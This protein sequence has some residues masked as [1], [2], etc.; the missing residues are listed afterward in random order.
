M[1]VSENFLFYVHWSKWSIGWGDTG[2]GRGYPCFYTEQHSAH[3]NCSFGESPAQPQPGANLLA[4]EPWGNGW[5]CLSS[6]SAKAAKNWIYLYWLFFFNWCFSFP[7][8]LRTYNL[9]KFRQAFVETHAWHNQEILDLWHTYCHT[10]SR[11]IVASLFWKRAFHIHTF[12][13]NLF[14]KT[15]HNIK[16][17]NI[18]LPPKSGCGTYLMHFNP[19]FPLKGV[20]FLQIYWWLKMKSFVGKYQITLVTSRA[21]PPSTLS[22]HPL[23]PPVPFLA[24]LFSSRFL[25]IEPVPVLSWSQ[26]QTSCWLWGWSVHCLIKWEHTQGINPRVTEPSWLRPPQ[27]ILLLKKTEQSRVCSSVLF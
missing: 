8:C 19:S 4:W 25:M 11:A 12:P 27:D 13:C 2:G 3:W 18:F 21:V 23:L 6:L 15:A 26:W 22:W 24:A 14:L 1:F 5:N 9:F 17:E 7:F 10:Q 16:S 20:K